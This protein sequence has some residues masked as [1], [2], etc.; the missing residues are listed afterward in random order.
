[1]LHKGDVV[2]EIRKNVDRVVA[3]GEGMN[4]ISMFEAADIG[5]AYAG[6]HNPMPDLI[7][8]SDYVVTNGRGLCRLLG[9]L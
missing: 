7:S 3:I 8:V 2:H 6:V 5:V 9:T 4:D 1:V